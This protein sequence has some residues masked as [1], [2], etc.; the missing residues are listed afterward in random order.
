MVYWPVWLGVRLCDFI[1]QVTLHSSKMSCHEELD[2]F[3]LLQFSVCRWR[4]YLCVV[5]HQHRREFSVER[6]SRSGRQLLQSNDVTGRVVC[7]FTGLLL[8][9]ENI[10][11]VKDGK[12]STEPI[13]AWQCD[14]HDCSHNDSEYVHVHPFSFLAFCHVLTKC[15]VPDTGWSSRQLVLSEAGLLLQRWI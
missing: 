12:P 2:C 15:W 7:N 3:N 10:T 14:A 8:Y 5:W 1:W 6:E 13:E 11:V 4:L 9:A